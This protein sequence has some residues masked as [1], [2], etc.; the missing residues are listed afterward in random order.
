MPQLVMTSTQSSPITSAAVVATLALAL[1]TA[2]LGAQQSTT[3]AR[4]GETVELSL[5]EALKIAQAKS[6]TIE[7]ARAGVARA[8]GQRTQGFDRPLRPE[9]EIVRP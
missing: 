6:H 3:S 9:V 2:R 5:D 4:R 8:S 7:I 1:Y